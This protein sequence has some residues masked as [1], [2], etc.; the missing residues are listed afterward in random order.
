[1]NSL[2]ATVTLHDENGLRRAEADEAGKE[3]DDRHA[4]SLWDVIYFPRDGRAPIFD[5]KGMAARDIV[6][7]MKAMVASRDREQ[8]REQK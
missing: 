1:M 7:Y 6:D 8:E 3:S 2:R 4:A 5:V